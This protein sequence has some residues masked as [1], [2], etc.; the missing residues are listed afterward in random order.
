MR[1]RYD[2]TRP[3]DYLAAWLAHLMLCAAPAPGVA[4]ETLGLSRDGSF[5]L[6]AVAPDRA[7]QLLADL[8]ALYRQ[9]LSAP[10]H[11]FPKSAWAYIFN[12]ESAAKARV[13]WSGG[14]RAEF[15][16]AQNPAYRLAL[17]GLGDPLDDAFFDIARRVFGPLRAQLEDG[18]L[19]LFPG[20]QA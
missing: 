17:R 5:R 13:K 3:A 10:L 4:C 19:G 8:L 12:D 6:H 2:D 15:G 18:R 9:G 11:F 16:E 7:R 1:H 14:Q 20:K